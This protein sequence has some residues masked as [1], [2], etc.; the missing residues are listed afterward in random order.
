MFADLEFKTLGKRILGDEIDGAPE[1]WNGTEEARPKK[2][3]FVKGNLTDEQGV[4]I[5][6]AQVGLKSLKTNEMTEGMVDSYS[7]KYA[8][9][10]PVKQNERFILT[11]KKDD[12]FFNSKYIEPE[13]EQYDPPTT[14]DFTI[15]V[16]E[17]NKPVRLD[18]VNFETNSFQLDEVSKSNINQLVEF[19]KDEVDLSREGRRPD[20]RRTFIKQVTQLRETQTRDGRCGSRGLR[21]G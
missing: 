9:A 10:V 17:K 2:V 14:V 1:L 19:M 18:N 21:N 11:V 15:G 3:L 13:K 4:D 12:Y 8:I 5:T 16:V 20:E 7:G 6:D